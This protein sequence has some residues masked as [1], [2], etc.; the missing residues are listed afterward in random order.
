MTRLS[1]KTV[2]HLEKSSL[3]TVYTHPEKLRAFQRL[4]SSRVMSDSYIPNRRK[5]FQSG[6]EL[7]IRKSRSR[8]EGSFRRY[9]C[10][11][12]AHCPKHIGK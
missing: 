1:D 5:N 12:S 8:F 4:T 7:R 11:F 2:C 10:F 3:Y 6:L 9:G